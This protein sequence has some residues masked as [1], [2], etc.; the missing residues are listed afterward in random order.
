MLTRGHILLLQHSHLPGIGKHPARLDDRRHFAERLELPLLAGREV[1]QQPAF[2]V[3]AQL[4]TGADLLAQP[5]AGLEGDYVAAIDRITIEDASVELGDDGLDTGGVE[6]DRSVLARG[7]T[8]EVLT[9]HDDLVRRDEFIRRI[10]ERD[11]PL[12]QSGLRRWYA[13]ESVL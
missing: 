4:V 9:G 10:M 6:R 1:L 13:A 8:A 12:G 2:H 11:M 7:A 3:D 5:V